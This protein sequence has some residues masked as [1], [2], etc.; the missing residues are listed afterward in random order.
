MPNPVLRRMAHR[1]AAIGL[2]VFGLGLFFFLIRLLQINPLS[3]GLR[4][5]LWLSLLAAGLLGA[6][7]LYDLAANYSLNLSEYEERRRKQQYL[8]PSAG[9]VATVS[10]AGGPGAPLATGPRPVKR[11][12][13]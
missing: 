9:G 2:I 13:R 7:A 12:R 10:R 6:Y 11:K 4:I 1:W 5:W 8:R 3:F